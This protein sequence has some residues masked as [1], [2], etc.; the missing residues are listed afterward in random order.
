M[1]QLANMLNRLCNDARGPLAESAPE[2]A[3]ALDLAWGAAQAVFAEQARPEHA[4]M[5]VPLLLQRA[6]AR[7]ERNKTPGD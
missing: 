7:R 5:L 2:I 1:E 3:N 6:D 4:I